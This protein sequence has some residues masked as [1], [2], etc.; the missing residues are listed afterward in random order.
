[1]ITNNCVEGVPHQCEEDDEFR[2][3]KITKGTIILAC[4]W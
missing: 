3:E 2:G 4:E 1:M